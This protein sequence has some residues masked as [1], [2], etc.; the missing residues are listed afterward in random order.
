MPTTFPASLRE[1]HR[2]VAQRR[3]ISPATMT[4]RLL[5]IDDDA[6]LSSMVG[7]YL[8]RAGFAVETAG[9]LAEGASVSPLP[10]SMPWC[11]T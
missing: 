2:S 1:G 9:S 8:G 4:P 5:L 10:A 7:D 11:S 6:R 3:I